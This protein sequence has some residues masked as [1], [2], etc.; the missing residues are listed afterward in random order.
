MQARTKDALRSGTILP[1]IQNAYPDREKYHKIIEEPR[2]EETST[3]HAVQLFM[4]EEAYMRLSSILS[5][6]LSDKTFV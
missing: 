1:T 4:G 5:K 2:L 6:T 3:D